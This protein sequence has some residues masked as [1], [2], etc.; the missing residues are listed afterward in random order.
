M[1]ERV[2]WGPGDRIKSWLSHISLCDLGLYEPQSSQEG[3]M[4]QS[5]C[6]W[7]VVGFNRSTFARIFSST[8]THNRLIFS[9]TAKVSS[10][11]MVV[12]Y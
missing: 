10:Q 11:E 1:E 5:H 9:P 6:H 12:R 3:K 4:G 7:A 8:P 2:G